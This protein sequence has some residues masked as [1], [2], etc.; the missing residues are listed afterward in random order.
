VKGVSGTALVSFLMKNNP[1]FRNHKKL[2]SL[3]DARRGVA[4]FSVKMGIFVPFLKFP[5]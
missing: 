5:K 3:F 4:R 2:P 1:E